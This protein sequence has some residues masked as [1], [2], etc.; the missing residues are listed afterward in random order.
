MLVELGWVYDSKEELHLPQLRS[1]CRPLGG[2]V[3]FFKNPFEIRGTFDHR[4]SKSKFCSGR[5][6]IS[7]GKESDTPWRN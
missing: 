6:F 1:K 5:A 7:K 2:K 4:T 3:D